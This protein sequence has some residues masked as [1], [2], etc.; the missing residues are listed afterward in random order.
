MVV[1]MPCAQWV[2]LGKKHRAQLGYY[3]Q[4]RATILTTSEC[5]CSPVVLSLCWKLKNSRR[6]SFQQR[7]SPLKIHK[8]EATRI[9]HVCVSWQLCTFR[10]Q[11]DIQLLHLV[12]VVF[13]TQYH[14]LWNAGPAFQWANQDFHFSSSR[15]LM[16][17]ARAWRFSAT[18]RM[19]T[20][21]LYR[22]YL[23]RS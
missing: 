23:A 15:R 13:R 17:E 20:F 8:K 10:L 1:Q 11:A 2:K 4:D 19:K 9:L 3:R 7:P 6:L 18:A 22:I 5:S 16:M 12:N 14:N 21:L